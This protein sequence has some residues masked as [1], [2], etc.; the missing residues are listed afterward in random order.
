MT[1]NRIVY[2]LVDALTDVGGFASV[3]TLIF[4]V[5]SMRIQQVLYFQ[6]VTS[7]LFKF[8]E[9]TSNSFIKKEKPE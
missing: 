8:H 1:T 6:E 3:I 5:L 7:K 2:N 9:N 4:T